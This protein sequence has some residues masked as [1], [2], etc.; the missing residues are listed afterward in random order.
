MP[1]LDHGAVL[2]ENLLDDAVSRR[3]MLLPQG[4][5]QRAA[6]LQREVGRDEGQNQ[7]QHKGHDQRDL[8]PWPAAQQRPAGHVG[9]RAEPTGLVAPHVSQCR[10]THRADGVQSPPQQ[11]RRL[12]IAELLDHQGAQRQRAGGRAPRFD[13]DL[14]AAGINVHLSLPRLRRE[15]DWLNPGRVSEPLRR[16]RRKAPQLPGPLLARALSHAAAAPRSR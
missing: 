2:D 10:C 16:S 15:V 11:L 5:L 7:R 1:L 9:Q 13:T 3:E 12:R 8:E 14:K 6:P 4:W